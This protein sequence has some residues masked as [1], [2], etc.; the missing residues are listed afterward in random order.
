MKKP[1][2]FKLWNEREFCAH[3]GKALN[4]LR[5]IHKAQGAERY[6]CSESHRMDGEL[7]RLRKLVEASG[8]TS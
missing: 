2:V 4:E 7:A 3:C 8:K 1:E 5:M 6:Y